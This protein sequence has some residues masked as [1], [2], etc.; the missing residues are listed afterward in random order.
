MFYCL[1]TQ[2]PW[3]TEY[4][5]DFICGGIKPSEFDYFHELIMSEELGENNYYYFIDTETLFELE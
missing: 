5:G 4:V 2:A 1:N 3:P